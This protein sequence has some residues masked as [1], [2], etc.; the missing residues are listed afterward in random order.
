MTSRYCAVGCDVTFVV[1]FGP[2]AVGKMAVGRELEAATGLPLFHNHM[3]IEPVLPFFTF[4]SPAFSRL[5][6]EFRT[7]LIDEVAASD[8]PGLIFTFVWNLDDPA[9]GA[10]LDRVCTPF[11][12]RGRDV[13]LVEL[14]ADLAVR[15]IRNRGVDRVAEKPS[16][17]DVVA[18]ERVL[19]MLEQYRLNTDG[20]PLPLPH[21]HVSIDTTQL[22]A[23]DTADRIIDTLALRRR[24]PERAA[25]NHE[26]TAMKKQP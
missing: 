2:P 21:R 8:L 22:S 15:L 23:R 18:S 9:D 20:M 14:R 4:G 16:K 24:S 12:E 25:L 19:L 26:E 5:V 3:S 11:V 1:L 7:R 13:A 10:F 6:G 17:R